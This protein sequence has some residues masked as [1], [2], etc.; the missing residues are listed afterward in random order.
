MSSKEY[1]NEFGIEMPHIINTKSP[2]EIYKHLINFSKKPDLYK[3]KGKKMKKWFEKNGGIGLAEKW[4]DIIIKI[5]KEKL[6][7]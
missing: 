5:Y 7:R 2:N 3:E 4:K 6:K 1:I